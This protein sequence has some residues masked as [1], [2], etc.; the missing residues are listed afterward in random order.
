MPSHLPPY[1]VADRKLKQEQIL[2]GDPGTRVSGYPITHIRNTT[3]PLK[4]KKG[5]KWCIVTRVPVSALP[6]A[7]QTLEGEH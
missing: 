6:A 3:P 7:A 2:Y 4:H 1:H 5:S